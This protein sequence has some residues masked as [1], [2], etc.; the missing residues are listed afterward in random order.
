MNYE[1]DGH[2]GTRGL[3]CKKFRIQLIKFFIMRKIGFIRF[4][5][6]WEYVFFPESLVSRLSNFMV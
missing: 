4:L 2:K 3:P 1:K 5:H 6:T